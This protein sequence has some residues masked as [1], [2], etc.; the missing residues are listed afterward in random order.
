MPKFGAPLVWSSTRPSRCRTRM[1]EPVEAAYRSRSGPSRTRSLPFG[2]TWK[3]KRSERSSTAAATWLLKSD[4]T[5][6]AVTWPMTTAKPARITNVSAAE[7][8]ASRHRIEILPSALATEHVSRA[9]D[10]VQEARLAAGLELAPEVRDEHLDRVR[11]RE[12]VVAPDLLEE[13]LARHDDPLVAHEVFEQFELALRQLDGPFTAH[14]LVRVGV[15]RQVG[16]DERRAAARRAAA[17]E[18]AQPREQLLALEGLDE[19]VVG[20][21]V[22]ALDPRLDRVA[23]REHE[24]RDVVGGAQAP[25]DLDAVELGQPEV[26]DDEVR[27]VGGGLVERRLAVPGDADVVAVQAQGALEDLRD[28]VVVL[29]DE[30]A[31]IAADTVHRSGQRTRRDQAGIRSW[32]GAASGPPRPGGRAVRAEDVV[33]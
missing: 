22:E 33:A 11:R 23:R 4:R 15:Q 29:D 6:D 32:S 2:E 7:T 31:G 19:V 18:R 24:D 9:A 16:D 26:E 21:G 17:Q 28:L 12:G 10:R 8:I 1:T 30:H 13:P 3:L 20:A 14:D 27:M 25:G 5:R